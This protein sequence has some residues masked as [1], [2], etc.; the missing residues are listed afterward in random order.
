[1]EEAPRFSD[2]LNTTSTPIYPYQG[3]WAS[4]PLS[5]QEAEVSQQYDIGNDRPHSPNVIPRKPTSSQ[6]HSAG[7]QDG[8]TQDD[9]PLYS[10]IAPQVISSQPPGGLEFVKQYSEQKERPQS[11]AVID[12]ATSP[13][14]QSIWSGEA[15]KEVY[16]SGAVPTTSNGPVGTPMKKR[17]CG[18]RRKWFFLIAALITCIIIA[19]AVPVGVVYGTRN[20]WVS[21][22]FLQGWSLIF[23]TFRLSKA[24]A[25]ATSSTVPAPSPAPSSPPANTGDPRY[26]IGGALNPLYYSTEGAFNGSGIAL[27]TATPGESGYGLVNLYFQHC[28][29]TIRW[30]QLAQNGSWQ[31]G[32]LSEVIAYNAKNGTPI[33][34]VAYAVVRNRF[35][36]P[37]TSH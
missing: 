15:D 19:V 5:V 20:S 4:Q 28:D 34:V 32:A 2:D 21:Y 11:P 8:S 14:L 23:E 36:L 24:P 17:I 25:A 13:G 1:M 30:I 3:H 26:D 7:S 37:Q 12:E 9:R 16:R 10:S 33:A 6:T 18:M 29:G 22:P 31:G 35:R 27:A